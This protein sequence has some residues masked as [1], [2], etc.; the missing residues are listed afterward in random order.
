LDVRKEDGP[1]VNAEKTRYMFMSHR[2]VTVKYHY[3]KVANK[4]FENVAK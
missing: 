3:V 1:E 4:L 2:Q